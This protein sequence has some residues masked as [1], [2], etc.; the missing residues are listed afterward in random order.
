MMSYGYQAF[1]LEY[2]VKPA[3]YPTAL[4]ELASAVRLVR[5]NSDDWHVD[6]ERIIVAGFSAGGHLA[7]SLGV[8]WQDDHLVQALGGKK[9]DWQANGLLLAYPVLSSGEFAHE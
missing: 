2:S 9:E 7:A 1:V 4:E 8:L 6:P 5:Q 3:V